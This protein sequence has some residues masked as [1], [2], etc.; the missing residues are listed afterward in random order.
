MTSHRALGKGL[1]SLIPV[2]DKTNDN[3]KDKSPGL[4]YVSPDDILP[5]RHQPRKMFTKQALEELAVSIKEQGIIQPLIVRKI[6]G[7]KFEL[8]AGERR[9]RASK[10]AEQKNVP[11]LIVDTAPEKIFELALVENIQREDLNPIEEALAYRELQE[12]YKLTQ[13]QIAQ[14]VGKER[15]TVANTMRLLLLP[16]EIRAEVI[17]GKISM[18]HA[19]AMVTLEND[20]D[21]VFIKNQILKNDLSVRETEKLVKQIKEGKANGERRPSRYLNPQIKYLED[22]LSQNLATKVKIQPKG[23]R[24]KIIIEYYQNEDLERIYEHI[25]NAHS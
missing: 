12:K 19:R 17:S 21:K 11:I 14:R 22:R 4:N 16:K 6:E 3:N 25:S 10:I 24:G 5:S 9:L 20:E 13:E 1:A 18:G 2:H 8:I 7:G 15:S 23:H